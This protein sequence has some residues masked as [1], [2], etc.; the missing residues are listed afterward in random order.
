MIQMESE[1]NKPIAEPRGNED[2]KRASVAHRFQRYAYRKF[3]NVFPDPDYKSHLA[4]CQSRDEEEN[5]RSSPPADE[6]VQLHSLT[7]AEVYLP[8]HVQELVSGFKLLGWHQDG[9]WGNG[10]DPVLWVQRNREASLNGG[11][12]N[13]GIIQ[14]PGE[15]RFLG[16]MR[17]AR[18]PDHVEYALGEVYGLTSSITCVVTCRHTL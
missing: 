6:L 5:T 3:P 7:V 12:L 11:W 15:K 4:I 14:P 16:P 8:S 13:L 18:L 10:G 1:N 9:A 17:S 2:R